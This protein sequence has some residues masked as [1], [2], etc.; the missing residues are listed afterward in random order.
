MIRFF[1][2][3][4]INIKEEILKSLKSVRGE[5]LLWAIVLSLSCCF[6]WSAVLGQHGVFHYFQLKKSLRRIHAENVA[7]TENNSA[8][9]KEIY[10]LKSTMKYVEKIAREDYDIK[11]LLVTS[12]V[13]AREYYK[14][15]G[16]SFDETYMT[17]TLT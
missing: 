6:L 11:K 13:G 16:Y 9:A 2:R 14:K 17:K 12:G 10:M 15:Y 4:L 3:K 7:L 1:K 5:Y 8:L